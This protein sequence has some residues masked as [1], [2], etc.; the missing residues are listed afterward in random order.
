MRS[1]QRGLAVY[2]HVLRQPGCS[3][4]EARQAV[5]L[6]KAAAHRILAEL[7]RSGF[8][9]RALSDGRYW[10]RS[11]PVPADEPRAALAERRLAEA[12]V[13]PLL[14]LNAALVWP[15]DVFTF[16]GTGMRLLESSRR[17]SPFLMNPEAIGREVDALP[18]AVGRAFLGALAPRAL[19]R[20]LDRMRADGSFARQAALCADDPE[21]AIAAA[22]RQGHAFRDP[23]F[24]GQDG[25]DDDIQ[26]LAV[27]IPGRRGPLGAVNIVWIRS[28]VG[29][30]AA[31]AAWLAPLQACAQAIAQRH[32]RL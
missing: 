18:T 19:G 8:L 20:A 32:A 23:A 30:E 10:P 17:R 5:G 9:W 31:R 22:S 29:Q 4:T 14:E 24:L 7:E 3:F 2:A 13:E 21:A 15:S 28:A 27:P 16:T 12:S 1:L 26:G 11:H 25:R 6:S